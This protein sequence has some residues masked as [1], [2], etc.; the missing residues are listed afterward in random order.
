LFRRL[1][2][3]PQSPHGRVQSHTSAPSNG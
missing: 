2:E 3:V 1:T